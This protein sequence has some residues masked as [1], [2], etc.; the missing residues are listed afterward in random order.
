MRFSDYM[1]AWLYGEEGYYKH[2]KAIGKTGDFYTA[3]STS[4]FFGASIANYFYKLLQEGVADK[5]GWLIEIG[6]HQGYLICDMI[7]WLYTCD[8]ALVQTLKFGIV[9]R[10]SE[11]QKAQKAYIKERFGDDV[12]IVHFN[13]IS[14]VKAAYAFVVA[15][16]ILDA[17]ACELLKD[18]KIA[19]VDNHEIIWKDASSEMLLWAKKHY[20]TQGEIAVGYEDFALDMAK[21]IE[22]CDF[23]TFDYGEKYVR[24]DF[25]I[26]IYRTHQTFPLFDEE[27]NLH[28][29]YQ[30]DDI[31]Y[32]VNFAHAS[33]AFVQAGFD[34]VLYET[35]AR[36]LVRFGIIDILER[37]AKQAKQSHYV[38]EADKIK[39]LLSPTMMGDRFKMIHFRK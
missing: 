28:E 2:F 17:F 5:N 18:E 10:Q 33:E 16:E 4:R 23:V 13:D 20:L 26:R 22:H 21:G 30:K 7:Q 1:N 27:L 19:H 3:V 32:D 29:S 12:H 11:V 25:S 39:T 31:T 37:F 8:P 34:E 36:A 9:E 14:E 38:R 35:Q 24:N 6:A 15:N